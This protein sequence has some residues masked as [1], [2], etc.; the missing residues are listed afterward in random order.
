MIFSTVSTRQA[1]Q[2]GEHFTIKGLKRV[3]G[4]EAISIRSFLS[5]IDYAGFDKVFLDA[6]GVEEADLSGVNEIIHTHYML[7]KINLPF[8]LVYRRNSVLEKWISTTG[9]DAYMQTALLPAA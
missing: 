9:L 6:S 5:G 1:G 2:R 3:T 8:V 4:E 7:Q